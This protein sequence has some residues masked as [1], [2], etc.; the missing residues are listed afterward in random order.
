MP[1]PM[2]SRKLGS[3]SRGAQVRFKEQ[4]LALVGRAV[5]ELRV[6]VD[7]GE[8]LFHLVLFECSRA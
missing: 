4:R 2:P 1:L 6:G 7:H 8:R 5:E 3:G